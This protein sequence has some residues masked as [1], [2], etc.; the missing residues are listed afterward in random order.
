MPLSGNSKSVPNQIFIRVFVASSIALIAFLSYREMLTYSFTGA[1]TLNLIDTSR[2]QSLQDLT[3]IL[4]KPSQ[5][6]TTL[7]NVAL[8]YRPVSTLS[9]SFDY[10]L[11]GLHPFGFHLTDLILHMSVSVLVFLLL[12]RLPPG[13]N[14]AAWLGAAIFTMHPILVE[15]V[16]GIARRGDLISILFSLASLIF[17]ID[18]LSARRYRAGLL[19]L[20]CLSYALAIA[21]KEP[22]VVLLLVIFSYLK[23]F[24]PAPLFQTLRPCLPYVATSVL[25]LSFRAYVIGGWGGYSATAIP[26]LSTHEFVIGTLQ[27]YFADLVFPVSFVKSFF[28]PFPSTLQR[29]LS[30]IAFLVVLLIIV[31]WGR[32]FVK[33]FANAKRLLPKLLIITLS[34]ACAVSLLAI[35]AYPS[36]SSSINRVV[37]RA[38]YDGG[39]QFLTA[40]MTNRQSTPLESYFH[41]IGY[42]LSR[43]FFR[44]LFASGFVLAVLV[45]LDERAAI[46]RFLK[47]PRTGNPIIFFAVW[48]LLPLSVFLATMTFS[49]RYMYASVI[50]FAGIVSLLL[51]E[52]LRPLI[53]RAPRTVL[54]RAAVTSPPP[55][56]FLLMAGL[57]LSLVAYSPLARNLHAYGEWEDSGRVSSMFLEE[58][59]RIVPHLPEDAILNLFNLP[60]RIVSYENQIPHLRTPAYLTDYSIKSWLDLNYPT[61]RMKVVVH[62]RSRLEVS[63]GDLDL[64]MGE[65]ENVILT[66]RYDSP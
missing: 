40:A 31:F 60:E 2:V 37:E 28:N 12:Q 11:W 63:P 10:F 59:S 54:L 49:H 24:S 38:Y 4:T 29:L 55:L 26:E 32:T 17:F 61:N 65:N 18:Y 6:G 9:F 25:F 36:V 15:T 8:F 52:T 42:L 39:P 43:F 23:L 51:Y 19:C 64:E 27:D 14:F 1:D 45:A 5:F 57:S 30:Q 44:V 7:T 22:A 47:E 3:R 48:L 46:R 41:G 16:P 56:A 35:L 53:E 13:S 33:T 62:S 50:P 34:V 20:S 58:L 21:A 66:V